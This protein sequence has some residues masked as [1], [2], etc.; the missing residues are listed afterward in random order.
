MRPGAARAAVGDKHFLFRLPAHET[1][2]SQR[3]GVID[4][5]QFALLD[6]HHFGEHPPG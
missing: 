5:H 1:N 6:V 2:F 3:A 4:R